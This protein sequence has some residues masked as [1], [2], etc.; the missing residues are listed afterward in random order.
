MISLM[1]TPQHLKDGAIVMDPSHDRGV[2]NGD[3]SIP[4]Q[5]DDITTAETESKIVANGC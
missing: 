2:M 4:K 3:S 1:P 5:L